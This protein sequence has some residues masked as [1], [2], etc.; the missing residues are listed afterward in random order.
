MR[1]CAEQVAIWPAGSAN[2][3]QAVKDHRLRN[4]W[5]GS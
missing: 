4:F 3:K 1:L 2:K 5:I